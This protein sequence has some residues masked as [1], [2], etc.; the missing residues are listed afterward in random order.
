MN[1]ILK[2]MRFLRM[3]DFADSFVIVSSLD[4]QYIILFFSK[5]PSQKFIVSSGLKS[6]IKNVMFLYGWEPVPLN[7]VLSPDDYIYAISNA[8]WY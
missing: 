4:I 8:A 3:V 1:I 6:Q 2:I 5:K 7:P